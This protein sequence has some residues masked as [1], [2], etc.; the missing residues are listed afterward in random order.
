MKLA[1]IALASAFALSSTFAL[2]ATKHHKKYHGSYARMQPVQPATNYGWN[3]SGWNNS[4]WNN[5]N[6]GSNYY[7][8][9]PNNRGGLVGG[10]DP[11]TYRP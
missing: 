2:A 9:N 8:G 7:R 11:G 1:T 3:N 4:G 6:Y 5:Y 10:A